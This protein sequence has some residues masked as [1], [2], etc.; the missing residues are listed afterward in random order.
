MK[1]CT[2]GASH[3]VQFIG[4]QISELTCFLNRAIFPFLFSLVLSKSV[5][6]PTSVLILPIF[7]SCMVGTRKRYH[8]K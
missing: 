5:E 2:E 6:A 1:L 7:H 3:A 4:D 8:Y